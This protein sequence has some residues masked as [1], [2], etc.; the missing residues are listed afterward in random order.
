M[1]LSSGKKQAHI[2]YF[3]MKS[4]DSTGFYAGIVKKSKN[5]IM[6]RFLIY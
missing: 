1:P 4:K 2:I 6:H 3:G 5:I